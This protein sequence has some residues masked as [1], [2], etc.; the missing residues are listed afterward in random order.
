MRIVQANA[1][2]AGQYL[3]MNNAT[4]SALSEKKK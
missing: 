4:Y 1:A 3:R 2:Y